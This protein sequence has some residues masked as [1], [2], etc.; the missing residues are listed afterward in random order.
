[1]QR[2]ILVLIRARAADIAYFFFIIHWSLCTIKRIKCFYGQERM[3]Q[4]LRPGSRTCFLEI[5]LPLCWISLSL[6]QPLP[7]STLQ[8][9][10]PSG[11]GRLTKSTYFPWLLRP[12][13]EGAQGG[14]PC[15]IPAGA[16]GLA[17]ILQTSCPEVLIIF[18]VNQ[19][20]HALFST[21]FPNTL[22]FPKLSS[23]F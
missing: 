11:E 3:D 21:K 13:R 7:P 10:F 20:I 14:A 5:W 8:A 17:K 22:F 2:E 12:R 1:M 9:E 16:S 6:F 19:V 4:F 23:Y 15:A 18:C